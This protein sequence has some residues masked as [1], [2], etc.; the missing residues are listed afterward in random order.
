MATKPY[1]RLKGDPYRA[2]EELPLEVRQALQEALVDAL[3]PHALRWEAERPLFAAQ[4]EGPEH[5][6]QSLLLAQYLNG[7]AGTIFGGTS[8]VQLGIIARQIVGV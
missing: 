7:R 4:F 6:A 8:E 5:E 2:Y 1:S 3:G